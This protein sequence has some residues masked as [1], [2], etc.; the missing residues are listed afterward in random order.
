MYGYTAEEAIGYPITMITPDNRAWEV[1]AILERI[2]VGGRIDEHQ[3]LRRRKDGT[4]L[5]V[6][7]TGAR[8]E[9]SLGPSSRPQ[10]SPATSVRLV[11][12]RHDEA[13]A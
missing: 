10:W 8:S 6:S 2:R 12:P 4:L 7:L 5:H 9:T 3:T 11:S 13:P 1:A